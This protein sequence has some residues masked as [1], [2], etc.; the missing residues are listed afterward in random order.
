MRRSVLIV[1]ARLSFVPLCADAQRAVATG[2]L[3]V[4][5][6][7]TS[8]SAIRS[9]LAAGDTVTLLSPDTLQGYLHVR[10][11]GGVSGWAWTRGLK[12]VDTVGTGPPTIADVIDTGWTK[13]PSNAVDYHWPDGDHAVCNADGSGTPG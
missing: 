9:H 4:R 5:E 1:I 6:A 11:K 10:T 13:T 7:S 12:V 3:N 8:A 2:G